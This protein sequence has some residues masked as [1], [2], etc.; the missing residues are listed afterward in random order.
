MEKLTKLFLRH[1][2]QT[3]PQP[4]AI[5]ISK[6][7]DIYLYTPE[8]KRYIDL[9]SG[10]S[11]SNV[12]HGNKSVIEAI[13][14]QAA[15]YMHLMVYGEMVQ[16]PQVDYA[17]KIAE[18]MPSGIDCLYFVNSG[19]E[20]IEGALKLAKRSTGRSELISFKNSYHGS[21]QGALSMMGSEYYK[22]SFRPLLPGTKLIEIN[23]TEHLSQITSRTAAVLVE[24]IQGEGGFILSNKEYLQALKNRCDKVGALLI[25]DE[26]QSGFGRTGSC[27]AWQHYGVAPHII[28]M[29]KAM[30]GG[31]PLGGFMCNYELMKNLT[32]D[33]VLGH[34]TTFGGHPVC[35]AAGLAA[36]RYIEDNHLV[37]RATKAGSLFKEL[38]SQASHIKE[39]RGVGLMLAVDFESEATR[40]KVVEGC[41]NDGLIT[42]GFLFCPTAMRIAPPLTISDDQIKEVCTIILRNIDKVCAKDA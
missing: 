9:I 17:R 11:V 12:G 23:N 16:S 24:P 42:E 21:T 41:V 37:E 7:E 20:A 22:N 14:Q 34:I 1:V 39:I 5:T 40:Q 26:I 35:C 19:S 2:G 31:M 30:G 28:C 27:F 10:V 38:L 29:A 8:G 32:F 25:F 3:S 18:Y 15:S 33:P 6:A 13:Q 36:L 4:M